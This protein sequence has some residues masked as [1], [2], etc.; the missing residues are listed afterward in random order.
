[1]FSGIIIVAVNILKNG[2]RIEFK[3]QIKVISAQRH[4]QYISQ[5]EILQK[6]LLCFHVRSTIENMVFHLHFGGHFRFC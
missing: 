5:M 6:P 4:P 1:M 3:G 2:G